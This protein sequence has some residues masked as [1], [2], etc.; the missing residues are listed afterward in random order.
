MVHSSRT[1]FDRFIRNN[2][3]LQ[4]GRIQDRRHRNVERKRP[5]SR[6]KE[7]EKCQH[8]RLGRN[9]PTDTVVRGRSDTGELS[10][11]ALKITRSGTSSQW[12]SSCS[13]WHRPRS[14]FRVPVT[15]RAAAF[16]TRCN[17]FV[18]VLGAPAR[19]VLTFNNHVYDRPTTAVPVFV[20][21]VGLCLTFVQ[22]DLSKKIYI[23]R[24]RTTT[25]RSFSQINLLQQRTYVH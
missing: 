25:C 5:A 8:R 6:V 24:L 4:Q 12:S 3:M 23:R 10:L 20:Y 2:S 15:T 13:I 16:N 19:T 9:S 7:K 22:T 21:S 11:P 18:T 1:I 17:L 14:N